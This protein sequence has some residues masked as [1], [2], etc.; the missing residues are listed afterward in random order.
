MARDDTIDLCIIGAGPA[1]IAAAEEAVA[2]GVRV[3]LVE[4]NMPGAVSHHGGMLPAH[5]FAAAAERAHL[6]RTARDLGLGADE[7][8]I[9]FARINARVRAV[10]E[11]AAPTVSTEHLRA[12][13]VRVVKGVARFTGPASIEVNGTTIQARNFLVATGARPVIPAVPGLEAIPY[14]TPETIFDLT[15]RPDRLIVV[16]G[17]ATGLALAQAHLRL[18]C[19]VTVIEAVT[20][21]GKE[22]PELAEAALRRLR[23]EGLDIRENTGIVAMSVA[24]GDAIAVDLKSGAF[25]DRLTGS[26]VLFATGRR[27]V[28]D[29]LDLDKA[30]VRLDGGQPMLRQDGRTSNRRIYV[31][32]DAAGQRGVHAARHGARRAVAAIFGGQAG[33]DAVMAHVVHTSPAIARV[34]LTEPQARARYDDRFEIVRVGMDQTEAAQARSEPHGHLKLLVGPAGTIIGA[35]V[36]GPAAGEIIALLTLAVS[37][38]LRVADLEKLALPLPAFAQS[39]SLAAADYARTH[40]PAARPRWRSLL[41]RL[42]P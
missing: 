7:P 16:G 34:G 30:R 22:D 36:V 33:S 10:I 35:S 42:L 24:E 31:V 3:T 37:R 4:A 23:A 12:G 40:A 5:A 2:L 15:R 9:N 1:G 25:E 11:A 6:I 20:A 8:R 32:G 41:K 14:F 28:F 18:G 21:L 13:G 27:P 26:H 17:G 29:G 19:A 39:V 38:R